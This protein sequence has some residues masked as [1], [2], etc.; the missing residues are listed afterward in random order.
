[1]IS[2]LVSIL[3]PAYNAEL[4]IEKSIEC[5]LN[6][7]YENWELLI[8]DDA[9]IDKTRKI[10]EKYED[11][12]I[13]TFHNKKNLG[14]LETWNNLIAEANGSFITFL[15][16]DDLCSFDRIEVLLNAFSQDPELGVVGSNFNRIDTNGKIK[17][18]SNFPLTHKEIQTAMP[19]RFHFIGSALMIRKEVY[20]TIGAYHTFFN[21]MGAEDHYWVY[22][23]LE[24][25][26]MCNVKEVLYS[27]R[28]NEHSVTGNISNNPNKINVPLVLEHLINQRKN[29][30]TD[31]LESKNEEQLR[32]TLNTLNKPFLDDPSHYFYYVAKRRFYEGYKKIAIKNMFKAIK[33][34][35][36]KLIY[37]KDLFY[38]IRK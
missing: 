2:P 3:M 24:K 27:Y 18:T 10:I 19:Q 30:G 4:Y 1:M 17:E 22:L 11:N 9:S 26:K 25:F 37:Y 20:Q 35:P 31:D 15:D 36:V 5:I 33:A 16:S 34:N 7:T 38:F 32:K 29:S 28:F 23:T 6:Q 14:Y 12:R 8:A 21:R 13:I